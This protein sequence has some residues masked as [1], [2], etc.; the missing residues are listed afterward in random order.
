MGWES[1]FKSIP[2]E[3]KTMKPETC[4]FAVEAARFYNN[5]FM[6][7]HYATF[8]EY[9]ESNYFDYEWDGPHPYDEEI[10]FYSKHEEETLQYWCSI[11]RRLDPH[12]IEMLNTSRIDPFYTYNV[13]PDFLDKAE[14]WVN[15]ELDT[16]KLKPVTLIKGWRHTESGEQLMYDI[17]GAIVEDED[18]N[19]KIIDLEFEELYIPEKEYDEEYFYALKAFRDSILKMRNIDLHDNF[20][21]YY[22]SF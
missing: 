6:T 14:K 9:M 18:G 5:P 22:Q 7:E 20:I 4:L 17:D 11:G 3:N 19:Q 12:I 1:G 2:K 10:Q 8:R 15:K 13:T 21:F 16:Q